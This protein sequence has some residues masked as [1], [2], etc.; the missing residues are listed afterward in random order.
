MR[1]DIANAYAPD[2][3]QDPATLS[4]ALPTACLSSPTGPSQPVYLAFWG[5]WATSTHHSTYTMIAYRT[6]ARQGAIENLFDNDVKIG[7]DKPVGSL[8]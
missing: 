4:A 5:C 7:A 6:T 3:N 2:Q 1:G 8:V